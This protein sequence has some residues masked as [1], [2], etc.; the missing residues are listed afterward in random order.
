MLAAGI[1]DFRTPETGIYNIIRDKYKF[2]KP[3]LVFE[4]NNFRNNPRP[5]YALFK[6]TVLDPVHKI[7]LGQY[8][9]KYFSNIDFCQN[10]SLALVR[11]N[12]HRNIE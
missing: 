7:N 3:I 6:E 4:V 2:E 12:I 8:I 5:F 1:P 10:M 11:K 9:R